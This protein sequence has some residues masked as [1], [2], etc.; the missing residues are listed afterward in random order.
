[1]F[2][3]TAYHPVNK[4]KQKL[5]IHTSVSRKL[6]IHCGLVT[7]YGDKELDQHWLR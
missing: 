4:T 7:L 3:Q 1:M 5:R 2:H 6:L